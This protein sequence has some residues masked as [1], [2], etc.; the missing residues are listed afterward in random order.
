[1]GLRV[2]GRLLVV[3]A[4]C[5]SGIGEG[6]SVWN[7]NITL[8]LATGERYWLVRDLFTKDYVD[9]VTEYLPQ[10]IPFYL[11]S[12]PR[13]TDSRRE[14]FPEYRAGRYAARTVLA[15]NTPSPLPSWRASSTRTENA[16][17]RSTAPPSAR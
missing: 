8:D 4:D 17:A 2:Q 7:D 9:T 13:I 3:W 6:A 1:M 10:N 15:R 5:V 11:F 14:F 16:G 12:Y